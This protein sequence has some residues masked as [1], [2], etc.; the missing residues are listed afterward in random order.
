LL[1]PSFLGLCRPTGALTATQPPDHAQGQDSHDDQDGR[2]GGQ[3]DRLG[4]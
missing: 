1:H 4:G 3:D 2:Q